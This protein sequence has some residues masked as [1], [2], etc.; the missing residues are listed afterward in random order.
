MHRVPSTQALRTLE[1]FARLGSIWLTAE[2]LHLTKSAVSH[3]LRQLERDLGFTLTNKVGTRLE[4]SPAGRRYARDVRK[5]LSDLRNAATLSSADGMSGNLTVS[6]PPGFASNWLCT[7]LDSFQSAFPHIHFNLTTP[8]HLNDVSDPEVDVFIA[9]GE[10]FSGNVVLEK[11]KEIS[12]TPFCSPAYLNQMNRFS[13]PSDLSQATL[14]HLVDYSEWRDWM[15]MKNLPEDLAN[16]G[17]R[18][19]DMNLAY[20]A[21][22]AGQG[23][24]MGDE[25]VCSA[26]LLSGQLVRPFPERLPTKNAYY[27][28]LPRDRTENPTVATFLSWIKGVL[29][30]S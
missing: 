26:A 6:C 22:L 7:S 5:A 3:Q 8:R 15:R 11:L 18:F 19:G 24:A 14:L 17:I 28:A 13:D 2:T 30:T 25:F 20:A 21:A 1:A 29:H 12:Y 23:I 10:K 27:L 16:R 9:F 4:L